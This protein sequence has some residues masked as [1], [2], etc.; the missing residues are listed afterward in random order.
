MPWVA[1]SATRFKRRVGKSALEL[2]ETVHSNGCPDIWEMENGDFVVIGRDVSATYADQLPQSVTV[3][4]DERLVM[5]PRS[6]FIAA[7]PDIPDD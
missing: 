5:V 2:G 3:R 1:D 6:M 7:K 4:A